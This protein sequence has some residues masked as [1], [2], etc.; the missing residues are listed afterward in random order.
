[1]FQH[2]GYVKMYYLSKPGGC[3]CLCL[4][5]VCFSWRGE[6]ELEGLYFILH[7]LVVMETSWSKDVLSEA[8]ADNDDDIYPDPDTEIEYG[9]T[10][11]IDKGFADMMEDNLSDVD[12]DINPETVHHLCLGLEVVEKV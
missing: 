1:M 12:T 11:Q 8:K 4:G 6:H 10:A 3:S 9:D 5:Y 7:F 2:E